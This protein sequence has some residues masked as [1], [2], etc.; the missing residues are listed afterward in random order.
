MRFLFSEFQTSSREVEETR[1]TVISLSGALFPAMCAK[2]FTVEERETIF[3]MWHE[4]IMEKIRGEAREVNEK[5]MGMDGDS[6]QTVS[7]M[8]KLVGKTVPDGETILIM[9]KQKL[10]REAVKVRALLALE[11]LQDS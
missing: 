4:A 1:Q 7:G 9:G 6:K 3:N 10:A 2:L 11:P 5:Y 8:Y